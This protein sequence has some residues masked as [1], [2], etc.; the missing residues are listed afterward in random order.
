VAQQHYGPGRAFRYL[1]VL[2][3]P[4]VFVL[5]YLVGVTV[6]LLFFGR[7]S[8]PV[9]HSVWVAGIVLFVVGAVF[10]GWAWLIFHK[11][12]TTRV[13]GEA[14]T[15]LVT[16]GPYL[17]S[18]NPM[19]VGLAVAYLGEAALLQQVSPVAFLPLVIAYLNWIVIPVEEARLQEVFGQKYQLYRSRVRRWL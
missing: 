17:I 2:P 3:V 4:W 6:K 7:G 12:R 9:L 1:M 8:W 5:A 14:S 19:Y 11:A 16:R 13:P 15:T 18:R 10:A